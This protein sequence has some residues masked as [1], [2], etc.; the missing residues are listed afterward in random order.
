TPRFLTEVDTA[1]LSAV[2]H[3]Y[4]NADKSTEIEVQVT[5]A[6]LLDPPKQTVTINKQ[7]EYRVDWRVSAAQVGEMRLLATAKTTEESDGV[8]IP[9]PIVPQGLKQTKGSAITLAEDADKMIPLDLPANA[10][11]TARSLRIEAS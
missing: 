7:G 11:A 9:L 5:G 1:T 8:E 3:N 10:N 2:V 4:L 6:Q